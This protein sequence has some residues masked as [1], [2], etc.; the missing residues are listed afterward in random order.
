MSARG[1][2]RFQAVEVIEGL[3][4]L[5]V[6]HYETRDAEILE[7]HGG[8]ASF[9]R[10]WIHTERRVMESS[11][12]FQDDEVAALPLHIS[13]SSHLAQRDFEIVGWR[14]RGRDASFGSSRQLN[15]VDAEIAG[16][17]KPMGEMLVLEGHRETLNGGVMESTM[18]IQDDE[19]APAFAYIQLLTT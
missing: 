10:C 3:D 13:N 19:A 7:K 4:L 2:R 11:M 5:M 8:D 17:E 1:T 9:G 18:G 6:I 15:R 16:P 14:K 12:G